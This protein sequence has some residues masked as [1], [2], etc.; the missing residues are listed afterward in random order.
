[1]SVKE[2]SRSFWPRRLFAVAFLVL[3]V[4]LLSTGRHRWRD[5]A[6]AAPPPTRDPTTQ[7]GDFVLLD[8][9]GRRHQL[10]RYGASARAV[11][12]FA[13]GV[14]C[15]AIEPSMQAF[16]ALRNRYARHSV[17]FLLI[18]A[19]P[20]DTRRLLQQEAARFGIDM[21]ILKDE[22]QLVVESLGISRTGE[23]LVIDTR[24][25]QIVYRGP[26]DDR[27]FA[28]IPS[29]KARQPYL[30]DAIEAVLSNRQVVNN[31]PLHAGAGCLIA[32]DKADNVSYTKDVVPIVTEKCVPCHRVGSAAP[33]ALDRYETVKGWSAMMR[34]VV[35]T[36]RMPPWGADP[37]YGS[38][39]TDRSL[40]RAQIRALIH[41]IDAGSPRGEGSDPLA[42]IKP[43]MPLEW[44]LGKPDLMIEVPPQSIPARGV[45]AYRY[46]N[47]P[48]ALD[49]DMWVRAV[50]MRPSNRAVTHHV[51]VF[52]AYPPHLRHRQ[53]NW[54]SENNFFA[55]YGPGFQVESF[56]NNTGQLL[57]KGSMLTFQLHYNTT[58]LATTDTPRL[59]LY[60]HKRPPT[61]ELVVESAFNGDFRIPANTEDHPVEAR[62]IF[63]R[64]ALLHAMVPHMHLRGSRISYEA[65]YSNG[66]SEVLLSVPQYDANWQ[67]L[68]LLR[69]PK[70][71]PAGT[72]ILVRG[73]FDNSS[74]NPA[75]PD[76]SKVVG[77]S[78]QTW[79]EMFIAYLLY[80]VPRPAGR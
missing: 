16:K 74:R 77:Y 57:P 40:S 20:Q 76:P 60:F 39:S 7:V 9:E 54:N 38:F 68:Y 66:R 14:G 19:N 56:P 31:A 21:P 63:K 15:H 32:M 4:I 64:D 75:N 18:N 3:L 44:P 58:G 10:H 48:L 65:R 23:A 69:Q 79:D 61:R 45:V 49:R 47:V 2:P 72:E 46:V 1:M 30:Q 36:Q 52:V 80:S 13:H 5:G 25:W 53:P 78:D 6:M 26:V 35:M 73:A 37:A 67:S 71:I 28:D 8:Q 43:A 34:Q 51:L 62:Y 11:V 70:S 42:E 41:W 55:V 50:D 12:M 27:M 29:A 24:T 33:W 59:A 22:N 17:S